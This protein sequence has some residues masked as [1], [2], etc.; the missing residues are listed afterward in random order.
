MPAG[1]KWGAR[2]PNTQGSFRALLFQFH[3]VVCPAVIARSESLGIL[4]K[5]KIS[6]GF[7][8][9]KMH[10]KFFG[11]RLVKNFDLFGCGQFCLSRVL[12][13]FKKPLLVD[14]LFACNPDNSHSLKNSDLKLS[15]IKQISC[16][17]VV[18]IHGPI[19]LVHRVLIGQWREKIQKTLRKDSRQ[20]YAPKYSEHLINFQLS[21]FHHSHCHFAD[22]FHMFTEQNTDFLLIYSA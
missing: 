3:F 20:I 13:N 12:E 9:L 22:A 15:L 19:P 16:S 5:F 1:F 18:D 10:S 17:L 8:S 2:K 21:L 7:L 14:C 11:R 4:E 6:E